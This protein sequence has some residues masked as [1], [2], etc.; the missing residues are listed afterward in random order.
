MKNTRKAM[1]LIKKLKLLQDEI[2]DTIMQEVDE[3]EPMKDV[4]KVGSL[5][6]VVKLSTI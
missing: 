4:E 2:F 5:M 1:H 6:C 3:I